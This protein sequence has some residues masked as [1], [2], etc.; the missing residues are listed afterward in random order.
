MGMAAKSTNF[1]ASIFRVR[2]PFHA[3]TYSTINTGSR[4][5]V[6]NPNQSR[7]QF[8]QS[9]YGILLDGL[10]KNK[11]FDEAM[12]LFQEIE[13]KKLDRDIVIYNIWIDGLFNA[14]KLTTARELF[15]SLPTKGLQPNV[16][17]YNIMIKG[18]CEEGL[19][20]EA[21]ELLEKMDENGCSPNDRTYNTMI[22]GLLQQNKAS[23]ATELVKI[24]VDKG[25]S[26][27]ATT[28]SKFIDMLSSN[29]VDKNI[30][31]FF[32]NYV[33]ERLQHNILW[34]GEDGKGSF[35]W[36]AGISCDIRL[37]PRRNAVALIFSS[38]FL[39]GVS[40]HDAAFAQ[41]SVGLREYI[42]TFD[43]NSFKLPQNWIQVRGAAFQFL[44]LKTTG[45]RTRLQTPENVF[46]EEEND[47]RKS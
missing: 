11:C 30:Q 12:T 33:I 24:I 43:G 16:L 44:E 45:L 6:Q 10:C 37:F 32:Q 13:D 20:D 38:Y 39:S 36:W 9:T 2:L 7:N 26:A 46:L 28:A 40:L 29:Q 22:Q 3:F 5:N 34:G 47:H 35:I 1:L 25:C 19:I 15:Y 18:L 14:G 8:L 41:P 31:E 17:A 42:Y 4:D 21:S 23:K 27:N